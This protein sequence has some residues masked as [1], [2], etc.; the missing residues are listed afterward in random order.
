MEAAPYVIFLHPSRASTANIA[1]AEFERHSPN[2]IS[3]E[4]LHDTLDRLGEHIASKK[5]DEKGRYFGAY[6]A[7]HGM[8]FGAGRPRD[9]KGARKRT[10]P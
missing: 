10:A 5:L 1:P 7:L 2:V 3:H 4:T 8:W 6:P 9:A